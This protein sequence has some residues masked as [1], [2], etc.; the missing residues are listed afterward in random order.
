MLLRDPVE[1]NHLITI[2]DLDANHYQ[3][4][5]TWPSTSISHF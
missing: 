2:Y 1:S 3:S 5:P 4:L